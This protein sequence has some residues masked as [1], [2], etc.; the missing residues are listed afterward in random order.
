MQHA[1]FYYVESARHTS[2][3]FLGVPLSTETDAKLALSS[4]HWS[5][6]YGC[7]L[8]A[9]TSGDHRLDHWLDRTRVLLNVPRSADIDTKLAFPSLY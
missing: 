1:L 5:L 3:S 2:P 6:W 7:L 8:L 4:F 9:D